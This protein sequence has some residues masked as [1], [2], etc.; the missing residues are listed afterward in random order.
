MSIR[1]EIS[2]SERTNVPF[3]EPDR[4]RSIPVHPRSGSFKFD[5]VRPIFHWASRAGREA[6]DHTLGW[7]WVTTRTLGIIISVV[8]GSQFPSFV[9]FLTLKSGQGPFASV[10]ENPQLYNV[11]DSRQ[12]PKSVQVR[13]VGTFDNRLLESW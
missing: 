11:T 1:L 10:P 5:P 3:C 2:R 9:V 7:L 12:L 13:D 8:E 6:R 4:Y